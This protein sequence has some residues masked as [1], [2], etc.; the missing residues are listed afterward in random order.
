MPEALI[1]AQ[2]LRKVYG[3]SVVALDGVSFEVH[4]GE[5]YGLLG[6]NGAGKT[7]TVRILA[8]LTQPTAGRALV[9]GFNV[10]SDGLKVRQAIGYVGQGTGVDQHLTGRENLWVQG[11]LRGLGGAALRRRIDE[12]LALVGLTEAADRLAREWSGGMRRRLD[13]ALGLIHRPRLLFLDEPTTGL[14]PESRMML[15]RQLRQL[16]D[17]TGIAVLLTTHYLEEADRLSHRIGIIDRGRIV[18]E[19]TPDGLKA[20]IHGDILILTCRREEDVAPLA[21][22]L[23]GLEPVRELQ[24]HGR[25]ILVTVTD[26]AAAIPALMAAIDGE[27]LARIE[28]RKPTLDEVYLKLTG[29][30]MAEAEAGGAEPRQEAAA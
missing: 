6:P 29:R 20:R 10:V 11:Q 12:L 1:E 28:L 24:I 2:D 9:A 5:I 8:T 14:D 16:A 25:Q 7:T 3:E 17:E 4:A 23:R 21:G 18:A 13:L 22:S 26:G 19:D 30:T 27:R 15:H